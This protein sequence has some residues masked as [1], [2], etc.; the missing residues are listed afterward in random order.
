M[1]REVAGIPP[2]AAQQP[3]TGLYYGYYLIGAAM[4]AQFVSV[5]VQNYVIGAFFKPMTT[6]LDWTRSEFTLGRTVAQFQVIRHRLADMAT[7]VESSHQMM[8]KAA[9]IK[10]AG[11]RN[12]LEA[13]M[14]KYLA[15]E[16]CAAV[17]RG[18]RPKNPVNP[19]VL[20]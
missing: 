11:A 2:A 13:G 12:D 9:R 16:N 5:G 6:D 10:D 14:A 20:P 17:L 1:A 4:V 18:E 3:K 19:E 15:A 8:V 7:K